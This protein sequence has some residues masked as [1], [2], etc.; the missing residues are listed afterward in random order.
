MQELPREFL[1][2][3]DLIGLPGPRDCH[4]VLVSIVSNRGTGGNKG[5]SRNV[6]WRYQIRVGPNKGV[7]ANIGMVLFGPI[8]VHKDDPAADVDVLA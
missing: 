2:V 6:D 1:G 3:I 7:V 4:I 8:V 5:V